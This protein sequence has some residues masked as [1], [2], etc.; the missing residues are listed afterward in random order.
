MIFY[1]R[2]SEELLYI[3][4]NQFGFL[5]V[6]I[7]EV[8]L[9]IVKEI[10]FFVCEG[11]ICGFYVVCY[12]NCLI[13]FQYQLFEIVIEKLLLLFD[14]LYSFFINGNIFYSCV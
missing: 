12:V 6:K 4:G 10:K 13:V 11:R 3:D 2:L 14:Y 8:K 7:G 5:F 9:G 1:D